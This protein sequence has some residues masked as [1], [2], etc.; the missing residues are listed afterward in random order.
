MQSIFFRNCNLST[1]T[2]FVISDLCDVLNFRRGKSYFGWPFLALSFLATNK[3]YLLSHRRPEVVSSVFDP[4]IS[5]VVFVSSLHLLFIRLFFLWIASSASIWVEAHSHTSAIDFARFRR[6]ESLNGL[7]Q[8]LF[9]NA[10]T[11]IFSFGF[12]R[13]TKT[14]HKWFRYSLRG[15]PSR[16]LTSKR[17]T[18]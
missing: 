11:T 16:C 13:L 7:T 3:I 2:S 5:F 9:T 18:N 6:N 12:W 8:S 1:T 15:S 10:S 14:A 4:M 17:S